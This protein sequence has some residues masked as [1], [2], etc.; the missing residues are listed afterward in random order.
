MKHFFCVQDMYEA[1]SKL[2]P[3]MTLALK[4]IFVVCWIVELKKI[5]SN[6]FIRMTIINCMRLL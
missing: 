4:Y 2:I 1:N 6:E 5:L 3:K